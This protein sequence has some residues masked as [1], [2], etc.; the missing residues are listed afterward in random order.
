MTFKSPPARRRAAY[1]LSAKNLQPETPHQHKPESNDDIVGQLEALPDEALLPEISKFL[2]VV[3][4]RGMLDQVLGEIGELNER[5]QMTTTTAAEETPLTISE[6]NCAF[7]TLIDRQSESDG[8]MG[9]AGR[10]PIRV[11]RV[12]DAFK[13]H[14]FEY[15]SLDVLAAEFPNSKTPRKTASSTV[16]WLNKM[17]EEYEIRLQIQSVVISSNDKQ[18]T[19]LTLYRLRR[20]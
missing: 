8:K 3:H 20:T 16:S 18:S 19:P 9:K 11:Q 17:W 15:I 13:G 4:E 7:Q 5:R 6:I 1:H 12:W 10:K 2:N 14:E